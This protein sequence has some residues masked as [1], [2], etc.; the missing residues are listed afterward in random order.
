MKRVSFSSFM[1]VAGLLFIYLP[2]LI[3]VIYSFNESKL[4]TVWGGWSIKWYVG[5]LDNTQLMGSVARSLEIACYTAVAAVALGT[6]AA[7]VLT[8]ISQFKGRTL[9]GGLVTAPLVMPEVIT[10]LSLLLLFVAMAQMIGWPQERG[11]VTIWIAH[12]TFCAA[13]V[14]VV[15]SA[16]LRE[17]DLSIEEAAM[18]LGARPWKVFFLITIPMIA[19][20][21]AAGGMM[22]FALSLDDLVLASFVSGPGSTTL[23]MEVFSAVRLGV[24]PEINAVAS[25][26]LLAV[27]LV[28]FLVW[29]FSRRAEEMRKKAIQQAI[30]EA[31]ADGW[32][33]PDKRRAPAPV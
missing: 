27:S 13:Y 3:L 14:A 19:P 16:R 29:F 32:Q 11:I 12:T 17:L 25:L 22:S 18:D 9:F 30:E 4:V 7:F 1:L 10:G 20:S 5:L 24:K 6:L 15:V 28:T 21:L 26:I 31:A 2:M 33:Q 23:P 8:R